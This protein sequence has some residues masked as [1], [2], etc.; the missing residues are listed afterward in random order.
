MFS[1]DPDDEDLPPKPGVFIEN[2]LNGSAI[3]L[4]K[5]VE[6]DQD[7]ASSVCLTEF[8]NI[9]SYNHVFVVSLFLPHRTWPRT[10]NPLLVPSYNIW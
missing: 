1:Q 9:T 6:A 2:V 4:A 5:E 10:N 8:L 7:G 3:G